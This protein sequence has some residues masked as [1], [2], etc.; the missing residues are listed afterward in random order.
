MNQ[1]QKPVHTKKNSYK[2][3]NNANYMDDKVGFIMSVRCRYVVC[4]F[5]CWSSLKPSRF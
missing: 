5:N 3:N 4:R 2:D 1:V